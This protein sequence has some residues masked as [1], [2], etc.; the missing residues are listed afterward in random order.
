M[1]DKMV[2]AGAKF[3]ISTGVLILAA[4]GA[5]M[6]LVQLLPLIIIGGGVLLIGWG[7]S[8]LSEQESSKDDGKNVG[9]G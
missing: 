9:T 7:I 5:A 2:S 4:V 8:I 6:I 1:N 3:L